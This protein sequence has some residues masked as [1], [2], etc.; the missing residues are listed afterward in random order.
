MTFE[1]VYQRYIW[2]DTVETDLAMSILTPLVSV[3]HSASPHHR[4]NSTINY[5]KNQTLQ[6][7]LLNAQHYLRLHVCGPVCHSLPHG[8]LKSAELRSLVAKPRPIMSHYTR[9]RIF[10]TL[11]P[12]LTAAPACKKVLFAFVWSHWTACVQRLNPSNNRVL[13]TNL[14][15]RSLIMT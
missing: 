8:A 13:V 4:D 3:S 1:S 11:L 9:V 14:D 10:L 6:P 12:F 7:S 15:L 2:H 5:S